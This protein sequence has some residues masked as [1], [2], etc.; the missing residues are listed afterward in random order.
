M[1]EMGV[2]NEELLYNAAG[3]DDLEKVKKLLSKGVGTS[4]RDVVS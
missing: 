3:D 2:S 4:Y 1:D